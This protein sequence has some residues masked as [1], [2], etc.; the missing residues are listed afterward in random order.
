MYRADQWKVLEVLGSQLPKRPLFKTKDIADRTFKRRNDPD[1]AVRNAFRKLRT[2]GHIE[3]AERGQYRLTQKGVHFL[4]KAKKD[5]INIVP[6]RGA[7][8][9]KK[10]SKKSIKRAAKKVP[11]KKADIKKPK[12][13]VVRRK[14]VRR[15][16]SEEPQVMQEPQVAQGASSPAIHS[17]EQPPIVSV[18][19]PATATLAF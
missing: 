3:I 11:I 6:P 16:V 18:E 19:D 17:V 15:P 5:G 9:T 12:A 1:R 8:K 10:G 14:V 7:K 4:T 2:E 13:T